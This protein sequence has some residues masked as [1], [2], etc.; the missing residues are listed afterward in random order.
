MRTWKFIVAGTALSVGLITAIAHHGSNGLER[1]GAVAD[2]ATNSR[3]HI[4]QISTVTNLVEKADTSAE[5]WGPFRSVD[6]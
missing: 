3:R 1:G 2:Q 6:W 4:Q 5:P